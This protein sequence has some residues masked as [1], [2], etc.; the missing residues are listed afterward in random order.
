MLFWAIL[1]IVATGFALTRLRR[2]FVGFGVASI[3]AILA[4]CLALAACYVYLTVFQ[5][6]RQP[7]A[8][9]DWSGLASVILYV[10]LIPGVS[11]IIGFGLGIGYAFWRER[12][13]PGRSPKE[14]GPLDL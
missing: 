4:G 10:F 1:V 2:P 13:L 8:D 11:A 12:S 7:R 3:G 9:A 14:P 6:P 5:P